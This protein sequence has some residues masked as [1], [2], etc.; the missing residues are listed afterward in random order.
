MLDVALDEATGIATLIPHGSLT[1]N[2]FVKASKVIDPYIEKCGPLN[3]LIISTKAFPG[4]QSFAALTKHFNFVREH[5]KSIAHV[6]ILTDSVLGDF[7][8]KIV[9]H[10]VS[11]EIRHFSFCEFTK[12]QSWI[13]DA[14][15]NE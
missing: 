11:S 6:A 10:F 12:A 9:A 4:W 15:K 2:D 5:H 1:E 8:E 13:I 7:S 3:G 14:K